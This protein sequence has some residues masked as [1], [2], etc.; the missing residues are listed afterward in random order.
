[1]V[2]PAADGEATLVCLLMLDR[3]LAAAR[4]GGRGE[5]RAGRPGRLPGLGAIGRPIAGHPPA[6]MT[7]LSGTAPA[8][9][10]ES[11][12]GGNRGDAVATPR[13]AAEGGRWSACTPQL[14]RTGGGLAG[15]EGSGAGLSRGSL[16]VDLA[17]GVPAPR[18]GSR[19]AWRPTGSAVDAPVTAGGGAEAGT[20]TIMLGGT[21]ADG[22]A[23]PVPPG[24]RETDQCRSVR[25]GRRHAL[26]AVHNALIAV[27]IFALGE[28]SRLWPSWCR[29]V[30][31]ARCHQQR[32][33]PLLRQRAAR[34]RA[35]PDRLW[36]RTFR[37]A[38]LDKDVD[39]RCSSL[40]RQGH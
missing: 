13:A 30:G 16:L 29:A 27:N 31:G 35:G 33:Q 39:M 21:D 8:E 23:L 25:S 9:R 20:L 7:S 38:L 14:A 1:V 5:D 32:Q 11:A 40:P 37:L 6:G 36:P 3:E 24:L 12:S 34:A 17:S 15:P 18:G 2:E 4:W 10:A 26:K 28:G 19:S 22:Q